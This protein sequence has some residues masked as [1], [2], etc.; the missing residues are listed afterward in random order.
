MKEAYSDLY[1]GEITENQGRM[2]LLIRDAYPKID[3]KWFIESW[4]RSKTRSYL[5]IATPKW[6]GMMP[7]ELA[8]W[9]ITEECDGKYK[10]GEEW[11]GFMP[12]WVGIMYS[13][14]QWKFNVSSKQVIDD[15]PLEMMEQAFNPFHEAGDDVAVDKLRELVLN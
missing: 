7:L 8:N 12:Q 2:F 9:F 15:L 6:A 1:V 4:M 13:L 14:Y 10:K 5:D 3:E 11:G